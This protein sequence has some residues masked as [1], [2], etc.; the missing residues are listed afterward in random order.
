[1]QRDFAFVHTYVPTLDP[2][3]DSRGVSDIP[4]RRPRFTK[5]RNTAD[6][7][8]SPAPTVCSLPQVGMLS[9]L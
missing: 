5:M 7:V 8:E 1:M 4:Q 9:I 2:R 3:R 6:V